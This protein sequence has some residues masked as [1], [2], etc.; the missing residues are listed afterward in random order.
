MLLGSVTSALA[1]SRHEANI[2]TK[3][4]AALGIKAITQLNGAVIISLPLDPTNAIP[5]RDRPRAS[6][7]APLRH[8]YPFRQQRHQPR[9][10]R[11]Q[12]EVPLGEIQPQGTFS[13]PLP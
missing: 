4:G 11:L 3:T 12:L 8:N 9:S 6:L 7:V 13:G 10:L 1:K 5:T 2:R